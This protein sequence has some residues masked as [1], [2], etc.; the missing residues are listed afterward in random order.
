MKCAQMQQIFL[1]SD[2]FA[3]SHRFKFCGKCVINYKNYI[4]YSILKTVINLKYKCGNLIQI[5]KKCKIFFE[6]ATS[7]KFS[8]LC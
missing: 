4:I 8:N 7:M 6:V 5:E 2:G 1:K 3:R